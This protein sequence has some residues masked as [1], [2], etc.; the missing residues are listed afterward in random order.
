MNLYIRVLIHTLTHIQIQPSINA[1]TQTLS[2]TTLC[3]SCTK[4]HAL[5][6]DTHTHSH[7]CHINTHTHIFVTSTHTLTNTKT[8]MYSHKLK[9]LYTNMYI[10]THVSLLLVACLK[11]CLYNV[12]RLSLFCS[13]C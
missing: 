3:Y 2:Q 12:N 5:F 4:L 7:L 8:L 13:S 11:P 10:Y 1:N 6:T 9:C